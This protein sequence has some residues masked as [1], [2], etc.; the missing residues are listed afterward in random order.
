MKVKTTNSTLVWQSP[1][2][3]KKIW[4]VTLQDEEGKEYTLKTYSEAISKEGFEG[5]V[6]SYPGKKPGEKFVKQPNQGNSGGG[7]TARLKADAIKQKE[8][9]AEWAIAKAIGT[10]GVFTP[11]EKMLKQ[12]RDLASKLYEMVDDVIA[13]NSEDS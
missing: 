3:E 7:N 9:R 2:G 5:D 12:V 11:D 10:L 6:E 8:I 1:D 4:S 13:D